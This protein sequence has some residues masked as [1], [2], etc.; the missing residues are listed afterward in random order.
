MKHT[1]NLD[2][3]LSEVLEQWRKRE[4]HALGLTISFNNHITK[5]L[6]KAVIEDKEQQ[7]EQEK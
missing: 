7:K 2:D 5:L 4:E 3:E 6:R 1:I